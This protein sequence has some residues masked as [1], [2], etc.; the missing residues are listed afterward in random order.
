MGEV[1]RESGSGPPAAQVASTISLTGAERKRAVGVASSLAGAVL[2][3][4]AYIVPAGGVEEADPFVAAAVL[5]PVAA[6]VSFG[7]LFPRLLSSPF[8][9]RTALITSI[10]GFATSVALWWLGF[11][12]ALAVAGSV[13]GLHARETMPERSRRQARAAVVL[14]AAGFAIALVF[15]I[16]GLTDVLPDWPTE[17][18]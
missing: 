11:P 6:L 10:L 16:L 8:L 17:D 7:R 13:M 12:F 2:L 14:G 4:A 18:S 1:A 5:G 15:T 9:P 3:I